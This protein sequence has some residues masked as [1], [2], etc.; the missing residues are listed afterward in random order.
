MND[1]PNK[2]LMVDIETL[3]TQPGCAVVAIGAVW[4]DPE[5]NG[6]RARHRG[7]YAEVLLEDA[8]KHGTAD[9]S[10]LKF[11]MGQSED[12][13]K[14]LTND[15]GKIPLKQALEGLDAF[16]HHQSQHAQRR[17]VYVWGNCNKFDLGNLEAMY[18]A[19]GWAYPWNYGRGQ[20]VRTVVWLAQQFFGMDRPG[21][22]L[23]RTAHNAL[24]DA[25]HQAEYVTEMVRKIRGVTPDDTGTA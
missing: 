7:Y 13:R 6:W 8:L 16:I 18:D 1:I 15:E 22:K 4:F 17:D 20:N 2:H 3:G 24:D 9:S 12:A 19:V 11:W 14:F 21:M 25:I 5:D 23:G 10:T